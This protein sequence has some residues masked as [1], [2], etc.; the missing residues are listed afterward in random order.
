MYFL[1]KSKNKFQTGVKWLVWSAIITLVGT[2]G[3]FMYIKSFNKSTQPVAMPT[4]S[5]DSDDVKITINESGTLELGNQKALKS[6]GEVTIERVL[7]KLGD[8]VK[9]GQ[10]LVIFRNPEGQKNLT[11]SDL[12]IRKQELIVVRS[13]EKVVEAQNKLAT[14][15]KELREPVT[16]KQLE[17]QE[18]ELNL[19]RSR[20]QVVDAKEKQVAA[21]KELQDVEVLAAKGFISSNELEQQQE[22]VRETRSTVKQSELTITS[23][24]LKLQRLNLELKHQTEEQQKVVDAHSQLRETL[25]TLNTESEELRRL[26]IERQNLQKELQKNIL[27]APFAGKVL[28]LKI[29]DGDGVKSGDTLLTLGDPTQEIVKLE[30]V[31]LD[32]AKVKINQPV[33]IKVLGPNAQEFSGRVTSL[34]PQ[35]IGSGGSGLS[36]GLSGSAKVP[37]TIKLDKP[38]GTLI[39]GSQVS[40]EIIVQQRQKV[41]AV[42]IEAIQRSEP[43]PFVWVEDNQGL[44]QKRKVTLG[45]EGPTKVEI[46]SGLKLGEKIILPPPEIELQPGMPVTKIP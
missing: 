34:Y 41:V 8:R 21:I 43:E 11:D 39:P 33:Q 25:S 17:I 42:N 1:G 44:V 14:E 13:R 38:S 5:V 19:A 30:L 7:I 10:Q 36:F 45:L 12:R 3:W 23:E 35:A 2:G 4:I 32:A 31:T 26:Q 18:Q 15:Q 22:K 28:D 40:V 20:D 6:P 16:Q 9:S 24:T 29:Q 27:T 37:A 46:K